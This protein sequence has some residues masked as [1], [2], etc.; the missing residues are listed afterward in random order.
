LKPQ[1][2]SRLWFGVFL[3]WVRNVPLAEGKAGID[4]L[5]KVS[6]LSSRLQR[7]STWKFLGRRTNGHR[8]CA[9]DIGKTSL[10]ERR[11]DG[12]EGHRHESENQR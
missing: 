8:R 2:W 10:D 4:E 3:V 11:P 12:T 5:D 7:M 6:E 1:R 9:V